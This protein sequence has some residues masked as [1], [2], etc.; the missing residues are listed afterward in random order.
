MQGRP[1]DYVC[2]R[3]QFRMFSEKRLQ[4]LDVS[5]PHRQINLP[6]TAFKTTQKPAGFRINQK[7]GAI[8]VHVER[9]G[10]DPHCTKTKSR[11]KIQADFSQERAAAKTEHG[12]V[13]GP[14][15]DIEE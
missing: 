11:A 14:K 5:K 2:G 7:I 10:Y 8:K 12:K 3:N 9:R 6:F 15:K 1:P 4:L 13:Q